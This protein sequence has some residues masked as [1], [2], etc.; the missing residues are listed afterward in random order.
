M[1]QEKGKR[2]WSIPGPC[3][4][5]EHQPWCHQLCS[6]GWCPPPHGA[7]GWHINTGA[8]GS[9]GKESS[10]LG[11]RA[12]SL[13]SAVSMWVALR[14][15]L[16]DRDPAGSFS[17]IPNVLRATGT[18]TSSGPGSFFPS[19]KSGLKTKRK[20]EVQR[21]ENSRSQGHSVL[22]P[23]PS[24]PRPTQ[25]SL[26]QQDPSCKLSSLAP[27]HPQQCT[28]L[29]VKLQPTCPCRADRGAAAPRRDG[30][31]QP[32]GLTQPIT[33]ENRGLLVTVFLT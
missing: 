21:G 33:G 17:P 15:S 18:L 31:E 24:L 11:L 1:V 20:R 12:P 23:S 22:L 30:Q 5:D 10:F 7:G 28:C 19:S 6:M 4:G 16:G 29:P 9:C 26:A 25:E 13:G 8:E 3:P 14:G 27:A 2:V 32:S